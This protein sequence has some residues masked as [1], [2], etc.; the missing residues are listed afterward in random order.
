MSEDRRTHTTN[1]IDGRG[2]PRRRTLTSG[3]IVYGDGAYT[4]DCAIREISTSGARIGIAGSI[5]IPKAFF[6]IDQKRGTAFEAELVWRNGT[7]AG[8]RFHAAHDLATL[9]DSR[10]LYLRRLHAE[11]QLR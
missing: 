8:L 6:L 10:L 11:A 7:Q 5:V 9:S 2:V 3:K 1:G 4:Y